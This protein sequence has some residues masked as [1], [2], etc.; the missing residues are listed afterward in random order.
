MEEHRWHLLGLDWFYGSRSYWLSVQL[1]SLD[2]PL[3]RYASSLGYDFYVLMRN[4]V[5]NQ[6]SKPAHISMS[7]ELRLSLKGKEKRARCRYLAEIYVNVYACSKQNCISLGELRGIKV[8]TP[9]STRSRKCMRNKANDSEL[10]PD[11][12]GSAC[13]TIPSPEKWI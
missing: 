2:S 5:L 4:E 6:V 3:C 8:E 13:A 7:Y 11:V 9:L 1:S 10:W 12:A